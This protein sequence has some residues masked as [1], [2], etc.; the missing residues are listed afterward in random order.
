M[1]ER[2]P[3]KH[4]IRRIGPGLIT[5]CVVIGPGSIMTSSIVGANEGYAMLWVVAV[6]VAFM[7]LFMSLGAKLGVVAAASPGDL[8]RQ[9][10]GKPLAWLLGLSVFFLSLIHI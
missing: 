6:S 9:H 3:A 4:W 5:A 2:P 10:A 1:N 7:L 8:I